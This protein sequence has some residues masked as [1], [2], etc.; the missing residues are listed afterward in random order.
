MS[1]LP[2]IAEAPDGVGKSELRENENRA[3]DAQG[4]ELLMVHQ[5]AHAGDGRGRPGWE[6]VSGENVHGR[7][8]HNHYKSRQHGCRRRRTATAVA[9]AESHHSGSRGFAR[10]KRP[11]GLHSNFPT[12]S[13]TS[14]A[15]Y[16]E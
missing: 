14:G 3:A 8:N 9:I 13:Y 16:Q 7:S 10:A 5:E 4:E 1:S 2:A 11:M 12:A 6:R 15:E